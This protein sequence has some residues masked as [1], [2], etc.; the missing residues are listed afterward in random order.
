[1]RSERLMNASGRWFRLLLRLYPVDFRDEMGAALVEAY[2][3][4]AREALRR[5]GVIRLAVVW[6][7][8]LLDALRNG[9]GER[10]R[11]AVSGRRTGSWGRDAA[12][13]IRRLVRAPAFLIATAGTL[14][15][16]LGM[17]AV[18][19]TVV[20]RVLIEP[21]PYR[22]SEDLYYVWRDYGPIL[23][24]KR[25]AVAGTD[26]A[27]LRKARA[28]IED[29]AGLKPYLGG[30]F[31]L[32]ETSDPMEISAM[33]VS[34][35]LFELLGVEPAL[36]RGFVR[37]EVG[38]GRPHVI[39]L[40]HELWNRL[41]GDPAMVGR[42]VRLNGKWHTVVGV[43]PP[44]FRF[45]RNDAS[46]PPQ[47]ADAYTTFEVDLAAED[48]EDGSYTAL[49][50]ARPGTTRPALAAAVEQVGNTIDLRD[51]NSRGLTLYPVGLKA[52]LI[53]R[54]RPALLVLAAAGALLALMLMVN[55]ASVLLARAARR[56]HEFAVS[57]AL[58]ANGAAVMRATLIE[59]GLLGLVGGGLGALAA[60]WG[61][62][63][64]V[65]LAPLDLPRREV[66][67]VDPR[68]GAVIVGLG[69]LLGLLAAMMPATR[70]ARASLSSLLASSAVRGGG[71]HGRMRRG[72]VVAQVAL[73]LV[74]L[75]SGGLVVRSFEQL[76]RADLGFEPEGLLTFRVR[77]P[78][79]FFP[80]NADAILF[81]DRV[82]RAIAAIPGVTGVSA[83][84]ALP[85][86]ANSTRGAI[87]N[88]AT[89]RIPG[90]P[91]NTGDPQRD[92]LLVDLISI[93]AGYVEVMGMRL[94]AG[95]T[96]PRERPDDVFEAVIDRRLA[97]HFFPTGNPLGATIPLGEENALR[98]VGVVEHTRLS[99]VH[100]DGRPQLFVRNEDM[101]SRALSVVVRTERQPEAIVSEV[102]S[103]LKRVDSRVPMGDVRTMAEIVGDAQRQQ[104]TSAVLIA[105]FAAGALLLAS[106]GLFGVVSGSVTRRRHEL[107]VRLALGADH[108]R[109]LRLVLGE[110]ALLVGIGLL[111]G[112]PG[113]YAAGRLIRG[114]L[115]GI[116]PTDPLTLLAVT[117]GLTLV[118]MMACYV[119]ARRVLGID[120][121]QSLRE[122]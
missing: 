36:G 67:T 16:G 20:Q 8:A 2:R 42:D 48:P 58:G 66:I 21:M 101:G 65:A 112:V 34:P 62:G 49:M 79:E 14:T 61:T 37:S 43:L 77:R 63:L 107:A 33:R 10:V 81:Q 74:L 114:I 122:E 19:Y 97:R 17:V 87:D 68:V 44:D 22:N 41:G 119:P 88:Q 121:A 106:M 31:S 103:T 82:E 26:I 117:L 30:V 47:R 80:E 3:D 116:S 27:E 6:V 46:S 28:V 83:S 104:Q 98:V 52:D 73:S 85:L 86:T 25:G 99:E 113:I 109:V 7:R 91:G 13:A 24:L 11:P 94:L 89:I 108:R 55:L 59:G 110:G 100:Q 29:V 51:F 18:V 71:G 4:R 23:D 102:R 9:L 70:A 5:G 57:R 120:P 69:V 78:P 53:A 64:L 40:S 105:A 72:M 118:T 45:V 1:M 60:I 12:L 111:I 93:R 115:V 95:R 90:A 50:R 92:N 75:S 76:L 38:P 35:N 39:V 84:S 15:V 56:E 32:T 96:F 54:A